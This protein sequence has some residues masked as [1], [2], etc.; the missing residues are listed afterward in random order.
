MTRITQASG[1][2]RRQPN[3]AIIPL[4]REYGSSDTQLLADTEELVANELDGDCGGLLLDL[5]QTTYA[6]CGF[7]TL[8]LRCCMQAKESDVRFG[9]CT[10]DLKLAS[11]LAATRLDSLWE[12][13]PIRRDAIAAMNRPRANGTCGA[14]LLRGSD[15]QFTHDS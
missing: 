4:G 11:V 3:I 15:D 9:L 7:L 10:L 12:T 8:L 1:N 6:G 14:P 5:R 2:T 13:F